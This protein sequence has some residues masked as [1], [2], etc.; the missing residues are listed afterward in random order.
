[1][2]GFPPPCPSSL[3]GVKLAHPSTSPSTPLTL[4]SGY[5]QGE[6]I[7]KR[8]DTF[9]LMLSVGATRRSR[10]T[11][12]VEKIALSPLS[13]SVSFLYLSTEV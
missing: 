7:I 11:R 10:S 9:P 2:I 8:A 13:I 12:V 4:R 1:M 5:A 6:R 3:N